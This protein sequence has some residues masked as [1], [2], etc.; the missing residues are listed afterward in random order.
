MPGRFHPITLPFDRMPALYR[1]GDVFLHTT[2]A[3]SFG[4]VYIEALASGL[5]VVAHD[6]PVTRWIVGDSDLLVDTERHEV[7]VDALARALRSTTAGA[8]H[9]RPVG[10]DRFSWDRVVDE[11]ERF[12]HE[13]LAS[14]TG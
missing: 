2:L 12:L 14:R 7:L 9:V 5:P 3:E 6:G 4:N 11:Y 13:V 1:S 8:D 10:L